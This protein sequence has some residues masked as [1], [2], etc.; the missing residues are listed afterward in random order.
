MADNKTK[1]A[2]ASNIFSLYK[3]KRDEENAEPITLEQYFDLC[4]E[5]PSAY[6]TPAERLITAIHAKGEP[7]I[8]DTSKDEGNDKRV[9]QSEKV[10][11]FPAFGDFYG[12]E[13]TIGGLTSFLNSAA[14]EAEQKKQILLLMGPVGS[15]KSALAHRL[16][17]LME[18]QPLW[19]LAT[20]DEDGDS[21][22][23]PVLDNPL[24]LLTLDPEMQ[25][26]A[27]Q[28]W[29]IPEHAFKDLSLSS[30]AIKRLDEADGDFNKAFKVVKTHPS[31]AHRRAIGYLA[32]K[33]E[34]TQD[35]SELIGRVDIN[36]LGEGL[37]E[38]DPDTYLYTGGFPNGNR[39]LLHLSEAIKMSDSVFNPV[40]DGVQD[41]S[42][43]TSAG[44][45][46][47]DGFIIATTNESE[48]QKF[49]SNPVNEAIL[50][51]IVVQ[52]APYTLRYS[53]EVKI[54]EKEL[55][56]NKNKQ[57]PIAPKTLETLAKFAVMSRLSGHESVAKWSLAIRAKVLNGEI[58][59]EPS[60]KVPTIG[61]LYKL[62][63]KHALRQ[64][65]SGFSTRASFKALA[66]TFNAHANDGEFSADPL[67]LMEV[68]AHNIEHDDKLSKEQKA[69]Y[70]AIIETDIMPEYKDF[71]KQ[72]IEEAYVGVNEETCQNMFQRYL[73][74]ADAYVHND[75][76]K[77]HG[78]LMSR[79]ELAK[80][81]RE[82]EG[83]AGIG[84]A[85][86]FRKEVVSYVQRQAAK[87]GGMDKIK[88]DSYEKMARVIR[89][90]F[91]S[92]A[93]GM[94]D[95]IRLDAARLD[96]NEQKKRDDFLDA[97]H[98]KGY[99]DEMTRRGVELYQRLEA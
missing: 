8:V 97:M 27:A 57:H 36:K 82:F 28:A 98:E 31:K 6:A 79:E 29:N 15:A 78:H 13:K 87:S 5:D 11:K 55:G 18:T 34:Q 68:L 83:P 89:K 16:E 2:A 72:E 14:A 4:K 73:A 44:Q 84:N 69:R 53:E 45:N 92:Y 26:A 30:W 17:E 93:E 62:D 56:R 23:S 37:P 85:T 39:G 61:Q 77:E 59:D 58:P 47:F 75:E 41:R 95:V 20:N 91:S 67:T 33:D 86:D 76:F 88:W 64:G 38:N 99:T 65:M 19:A 90:R 42:Y 9:F 70:I 50:D 49:K 32:A 51:R 74:L 35:V 43:S 71:L 96:E 48:W 46:P 60:G 52:E 10:K 80:A 12:I 94:R 40:L 63:T 22:I 66:D 81:L 7:Q 1:A 54:L 25:A 3:A 24:A 21:Q